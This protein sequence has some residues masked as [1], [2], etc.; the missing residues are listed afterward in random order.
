MINNHVKCNE[1]TISFGHAAKNINERLRASTL[2]L[3]KIFVGKVIKVLERKDEYNFDGPTNKASV[4]SKKV[5]MSF[6]MNVN[7]H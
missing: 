6:D 5:K 4:I 1:T 7:S 3:H 2:W